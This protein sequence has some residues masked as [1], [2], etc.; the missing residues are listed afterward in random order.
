MNLEQQNEER[1][2]ESHPIQHAMQN[3][4][5]MSR[6][7]LLGTIVT[8]AEQNFQGEKAT[9]GDVTKQNFTRYSHG[10]PTVL[11]RNILALLLL[12][13]YH[14]RIHANEDEFGGLFVVSIQ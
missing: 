12:A 1:S 10:T 13:F 9:S 8:N 7:R 3:V 5:S 4:A 2:F 6:F 14:D 11:S